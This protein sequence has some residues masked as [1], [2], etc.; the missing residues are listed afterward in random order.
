LEKVSAIRLR[1]LTEAQKRAYRIA[2]NKLT[3][4]GDWDIDFLALEFSDLEKLDLDF[5]LDIRL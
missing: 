2:D 5:R 1:H 3:E 4:N